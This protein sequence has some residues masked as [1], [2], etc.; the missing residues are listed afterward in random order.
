MNYKEEIDNIGRNLKRYASKFDGVIV[1][2]SGGLDSAIVAIIA[3][4]VLGKDKVHCYYLPM[5]NKAS[6]KDR[7]D[8]YTLKD[9]FDLDLKIDTIGNVVEYFPNWDEKLTLGNIQAR[10]RMVYLY[11][12]ANHFNSI[13]LGTTNL[14][15]YEV[16]YL[17]KWGDGACDVEPLLGYTKT[18]LRKMAEILGVPNS[19]LNKAPS[20]G[21]WVGQTDEDELGMTYEEIDSC[22]D[23]QRGNTKKRPNK[24]DRYMELY[25]LSEHKKHMPVM[26]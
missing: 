10:V 15:E 14:S 16:G 4:R 2:V 22:I 18:E 25:V 13:V 8:V 26:L 9:K 3:R 20:A 1:G 6:D 11:A 17:T 19:I 21:L 24:F 12:C 7:D 23:Y 5:W